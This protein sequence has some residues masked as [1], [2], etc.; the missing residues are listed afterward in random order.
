MCILL[1]GDGALT[2][3]RFT[4]RVEAI[5]KEEARFP[6]IQHEHEDRATSYHLAGQDSDGVITDP[7]EYQL[8]LFERAKQ[9]NTIAVLDTGKILS[10]ETGR[11]C[12]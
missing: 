5:S 4:K 2:Q 9:Q 10:R 1:T 3:R 11:F 7:R 12:F 8:E 6:K